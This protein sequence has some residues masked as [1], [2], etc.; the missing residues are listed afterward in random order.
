MEFSGVFHD[1]VAGIPPDR[2]VD[3]SI[4]LM[5]RTVPISKAPVEM[6]ELKDQIQ[7]LI[8]KGFIRPIFID[9]IRIYSK[10]REDQSQ[11]LR[12]VLQTLQDRRMYAKF[13]KC[14]FWLDRVAFLGH[15]V[16]QNGIDVDPSK[17]EVVRDWPVPKSVTEIRNFLGLAGYYRKFIQGFSYIMVPMTV[18]TK[19]NVKFIWGLSVRR[20][21][22]D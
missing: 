13:N 10:S 11:H 1:D 16:S 12:T 17:V 21:L 22:I 5:S 7:D 19:K 3:F 2:E 9:D 4:E 6:N 15:I 18:L 14:E 20:A 8:D